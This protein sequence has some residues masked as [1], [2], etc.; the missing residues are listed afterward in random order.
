M[1]RKARS[2]VAA[3]VAFTVCMVMSTVSSFA[4]VPSGSAL[5]I[6]DG[7]YIEFAQ[8]SQPKNVNGRIMVP[9][10]AIFE[11]LG[12]E[13]GYDE[14]TKVI[15]G[16]TDEFTLTMKSKDPVI[17]LTYKD[18]T[19]KQRT[20]DVAPYVSGGRT[21][22]P[23]RFVS[24]MLDYV[25]GWDGDYKTVV[26]IDA[27]SIAK[28][29]EKDFSTLLK[30][31]DL[32]T[33]SDK[34]YEMKGDMSANITSEG[35]D[36]NMSADMS[37]IVEGINEEFD[38]NLTISAGGETQTVKSK[39]KFDGNTGDM[40]IKAEGVTEEAQWMKFNL[41]ELL[42]GYGI[43]FAAML[44]QA[45]NG[46]VDIASIVS[47]MIENMADQFTITTYDEIMTAYDGLKSIL[48]ND[49]FK[50]AGNSYKA[51]FNKDIEGIVMKG[52]AAV[53]V[54][55]QDKATG[56][57]LDLNIEDAGA[58]VGINIKAQGLD[59]EISLKVDD[60]ESVKMNIN[61]GMNFKETNKHPDV[62]IPSGE[63]VVDLNDLFGDL[64]TDIAA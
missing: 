36:M 48:G 11:Y 62:T 15:S 14:N 27:D 22:V 49:S 26:I 42:Q 46:N 41:S 21:F 12:L 50:K 59:T 52:S 51:D 10:R 25:V 47:G 5:V 55:S 31:Q 30:I 34:A 56:Y 40:Y 8:D 13:V 32:N 54:N 28:S 43:D 17:K 19:V 63:T 3:V 4:A 7:K 1:N 38:M 35:Q 61:V 53:N 58:V 64:I 6:M 2:I 9:Y 29:I 24:E 20:M 57:S 37:G 44:Q 23:T 33:D 16:K 45:N 18:G 39:V 60:G